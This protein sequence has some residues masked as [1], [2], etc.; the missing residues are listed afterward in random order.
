MKLKLLFTALV[1]SALQGM[2]QDA[3]K[4]FDEVKNV[5]IRNSGIIEKNNVVKGYYNFYEFDKVDRKTRLFKL[6]LMDENLNSLGTKEIEGPKE[7]ELISVGFDGNNFCLKFW[8][9]KAKAFEMKVYDQQA[10]EIN[11]VSTE[12]NYKPSSM[13][14]NTFHSSVSPELNIVGNNG[15]VNYTFNE[16]N[17]A[18]I[19]S[20]VGTTVQKSWE[21]T[22]EPEGKSKIMLPNYLNGNSEIILTAVTR[23]ERGLYTVNTQ[24]LMV[25]NSVKDGRQ[26]FE[27]S[28]EFDGNNH[29]VPIN[30]V[31]EDNKIIVIGLNYKQAKTFTTPPDGFAFLEIDKTGKLLKSNFKTFD[32]SLG[33]YLPMEDGK[34]QG[35]YFLYIHDIVKTNKN[36]NLVIA[37]KFKKPGG[38]GVLSA[39]ATASSMATASHTSLVALQLENMVVI[40][41][42]NNGNAI[43]AQ[44]IPKAKG[45]SQ[46]FPAYTGLLSPY[47][48]ATM[49]KFAGQMDYM[50]TLKS[51]DNAEITFSFVDYEKLNE[52]AKKTKNF[53]QIKYK[54][55]KIT[56]DKIAIKKENATWSY[57]LPG[58]TNHVIQVN[59]FKKE[60]KMT[61]DMIKLN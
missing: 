21:Q 24:N 45:S 55:G 42:D 27:M 47:F 50:Y 49:A 26:L 39:L 6:N 14:Y 56:V 9:E 60:K 31:F 37:E 10:K 59:Y 38:S 2:S 11:S 3:S 30:A 57:I 7:W 43:L 4:V 22:Y 8:D 13:K 15:F 58:K 12:I 32:E 25:A 29:V 1:C 44:E 28:M 40:E 33:K 53:G 54:A 19:I 61:M 23:V 51:D 17:D 35:G 16:P 48:L 36:T 20:Y 46:S 41:Y 18:Y 5:T 34:L 52:D